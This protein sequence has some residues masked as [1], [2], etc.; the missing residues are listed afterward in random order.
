MD[1]SLVNKN[2]ERDQTDMTTL[3]LF[4]FK[5]TGNNT[6]TM[7]IIVLSIFLSFPKLSSE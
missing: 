1:C 2:S 4:L 5:Q 3:K 6:G 7:Y